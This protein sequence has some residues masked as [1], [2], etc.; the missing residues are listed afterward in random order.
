MRYTPQESVAALGEAQNMCTWG[1]P[2]PERS[3]I[4]EER[5]R[6]GASNGLRWPRAGLAGNM[7]SSPPTS[8][9]DSSLQFK[10]WALEHPH[11]LGP[12]NAESRV[13]RVRHPEEGP[14]TYGSTRPLGV[15]DK[16]GC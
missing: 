15:G 12:R 1:G 2:S 16:A 6:P 11:Y 7:A 3:H 8:Q 14:A 5:G 9:S 13:C 10:V 4:G